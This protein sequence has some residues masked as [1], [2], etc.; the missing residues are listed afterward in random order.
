[1]LVGASISLTT[2]VVEMAVHHHRA[3]MIAVPPRLH[4]PVSLL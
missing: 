4:P 1:M 3:T 2:P